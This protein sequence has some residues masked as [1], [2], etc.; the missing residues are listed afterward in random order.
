MSSIRARLVCGYPAHEF[1]NIKTVEVERQKYHPDTGVPYKIVEKTETVVA[2]DKEYPLKGF[3]I[4]NAVDVKTKTLL[5]FYSFGEHDSVN[6]RIINGVI[7]VA[8]STGDKQYV[9]LDVPG[10]QKRLMDTLKACDLFGPVA[11]KP[12]K[13]YLVNYLF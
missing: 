3:C 11:D 9:L 2:F 13:M 1:I 7:G 12:A 4:H 10:L 5:G 6:D 8:V